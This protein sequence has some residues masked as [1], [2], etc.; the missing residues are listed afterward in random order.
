MPEQH[1]HIISATLIVIPRIEDSM[2]SCP[3]QTKPVHLDGKLEEIV[4]AFALCLCLGR[5]I[6]P[7]VSGRVSIGR[8]G[9]GQDG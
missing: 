1:W 5:S 9:Q 8:L 6:T 7:H 3:R 4:E 2:S